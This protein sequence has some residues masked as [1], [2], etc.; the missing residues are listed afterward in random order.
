MKKIFALFFVLLISLQANAAMKFSEAYEMNDKKPMAVLVYSD[1]ASDYGSALYQFKA[2]QNQIGDL[3][4]YV[5]V[6]L[7]S[8]QV[9]DYTEKNV[10]LTKLPYIMLFRSKCKFARVIDRD[11]LSDSS[12]VVSKMKTFIRQ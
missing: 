12:C 11:C 1:R 2:A 8:S 7:S 3:Y 10:I 6:N 4:N 5:E 9:L